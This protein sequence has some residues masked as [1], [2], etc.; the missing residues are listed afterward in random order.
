M[1]RI[2]RLRIGNIRAIAELDLAVDPVTVLIGENG[3]GK[4]TI[5]EALELLRKSAESSFFQQFY[6]IHRGM[7]GLLRR[8]E[9]TLRLGVVVEDDAGVEPRLEYE[10]VLRDRGDGAVVH[11]EKLVEGT[12]ALLER[13]GGHISIAAMPGATRFPGEALRGH[14]L[15]IA[16][17]GAVPPLP[18]MSRILEVLRGIEVHL[19]FDTMA[20]WAARSYQYPSGIRGSVTLQPADRLALLGVNL[21]N[22]WSTIKNADSGSWEHAMALVRLGLGEAIDAVNVVA[23]PSGG[24]IG[25]SIKRTDFAEPIPAASLS[26]GQLSWLAFV[27][28]AQLH[29][30]RSVLVIDEPEQHLHPALLGRAVEL[31]KAMRAGPVVLSTHSDRVLELVDASAV[32]VCR[33]EPGAR[34]SVAQI[35]A[36]QLPRW[37]QEF[38][39]LAQIRANGYLERVLKD[40]R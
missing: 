8:G 18:A 16:A 19:P 14:Q 31:L 6:T 30:A 1:D 37:L 23:D 24:S 21:A 20:G 29:E 7:P 2:K 28:L 5:V 9:S 15:L 10:F 27:A 25:L 36:E 4:S 38:G 34:A 22:A 33:L 3:S 39:D 12:E 40:D 35:D 26:D 13:D 11:S 17:F 32:R